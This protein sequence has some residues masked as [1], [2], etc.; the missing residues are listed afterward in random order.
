MTMSREQYDAID[1]LHF[2]TLKE[3]A[4]SPAHYKAALMAQ[5]EATDA[6]ELGTAF[7]LLALEPEREGERLAVWDE[8]TRRGKAWDAFKE[9]HAGKVLLTRDNYETAQAMAKSVRASPM[10]K[11]YLVGGK[12]EVTLQWEE[13]GFKC[14]GRVDYLSTVAVDLKSTRC[15]AVEAFGRQMW[16]SK[17]AAQL[18]FYRAG[19][20]A[21]T[22]LMV[23]GVLIATENS[24]PFVTQVYRLTEWQL[25]QGATEYRAW[26]STLKHC[27]ETKTWPGYAT[28]ETELV[29]PRWAIPE[30]AFQ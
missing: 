22:G 15:A 25:E 17:A 2:S 4:R 27:E 19:I 13:Q 23:P 11:P 1:A 26:L 24:F 20:L 6:M 7:H 30:E 9:K 16:D 29:F 3:F 18:A 14:K 21:Q 8:G 10:A 12:A 5:R 28:G